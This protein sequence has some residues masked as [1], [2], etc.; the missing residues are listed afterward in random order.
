ML[1]KQKIDLTTYNLQFESKNLDT[2]Q[3]IKDFVNSDILPLSY[4]AFRLLY[5]VVGKYVF[6]D[7]AHFFSKRIV[8]SLV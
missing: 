6:S 8:L 3:K 4:T 7:E 1:S 5:T 2:E